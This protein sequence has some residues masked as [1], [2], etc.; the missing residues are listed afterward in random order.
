MSWLRFFHTSPHSEAAHLTAFLTYTKI[1][2]SYSGIS[3]VYWI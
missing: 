1:F 2:R 3:F